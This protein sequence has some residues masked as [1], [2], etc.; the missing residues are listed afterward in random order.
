MSGVVRHR[1][2]NPPGPR[3]P[4]PAS[5]P[6]EAEAE[7]D[8]PDRLPNVPDN[9]PEKTFNLPKNLA[10]DLEN[11]A[12]VPED[13]D[14]VEPEGTEMLT[15]AGNEHEKSQVDFLFSCFVLSSI[16]RKRK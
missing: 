8:Q 14:N 13:V 6:A 7:A 16:V 11:L 5:L 9:L 4:L 1:K 15:E 10:K 2:K 12:K 3:N